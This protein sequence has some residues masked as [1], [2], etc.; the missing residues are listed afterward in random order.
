MKLINNR[1]INSRRERDRHNCVA[2][3]WQRF[4]CD[5]I[6]VDKEELS[7]TEIPEASSG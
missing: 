6:K 1:V 4:M 2:D 7:N 5:V 3:Q